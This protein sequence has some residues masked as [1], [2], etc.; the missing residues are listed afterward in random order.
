M[1]FSCLQSILAAQQYKYAQIHCKGLKIAFTN[2]FFGLMLKEKAPTYTPTPV[3]TST[4]ALISTRFTHTH[5]CNHTKTHTRYKVNP[6]TKAEIQSP[7]LEDLVFYSVV[8]IGRRTSWT[9]LSSIICLILSA[10][11]TAGYPYLFCRLFCLC[12]LCLPC[13]LPSSLSSKMIIQ[14]F[15]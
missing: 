7:S 10:S 15:C 1:V 13:M 8:F 4:P 5:L 2:S 14:V 6:N 3:H 9:Q 12:F 11:S